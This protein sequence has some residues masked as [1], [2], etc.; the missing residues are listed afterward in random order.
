[1]LEVE[2]YKFKVTGWDG[3]ILP[4]GRGCGKARFATGNLAWL[5]HK[6][7]KGD[8]K[9]TKFVLCSLWNLGDLGG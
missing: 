4:E 6:D 8:A 7:P 3:V 2:S 1:M 9:C 5:Y